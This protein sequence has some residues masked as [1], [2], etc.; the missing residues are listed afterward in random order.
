MCDVC[1]IYDQYVIDI[2]IVVDDIVLVVS[3]T[4]RCVVGLQIHYYLVNTQQD[5]KH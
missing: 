5:A 4:F 1:V 3:Q 2:S